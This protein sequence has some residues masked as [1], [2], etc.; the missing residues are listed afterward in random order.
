MI[1]G[2]TGENC[3]GKGVAAEY[4]MKKS[5]YYYSL[6]DVIREQLKEQGIPI[7]RENMI[8]K[9]NQLR[10]SLGPGALGKMVAQK[11]EEDKNY[12]IDSIR[13]PAEVEELKKLGR[14]FLFYI[15]APPKARFERIKAR[16]R[17]EDPKSYD[18][19]RRLEKLEAENEDKT[20]QN[21]KGTARLA[22][23][24][25]END[26][27][28]ELLQ[29]RIDNALAGLTNEF[30]IVRPGWD[31]YFMKIAK[32]VATR[33]N[34]VKRK[35]AAIIVKDKRIIST[36]YNGTPRGTKNCCDGGCPRCNN[37][38]EGGKNLEECYCSHGEENAIV[39][40]S[41]HG[42]SIKDS[43]IYTTFSPCLLCTKMIINAGIKEV[44]YNV[45]YPMGGSSLNLLKE[46]GV[47]VRQCKID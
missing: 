31:E 20:K 42:V 24:K 46:A 4:L 41:Y 28:L 43:T 14:F 12:V 22:D 30:K 5:F 2:L 13:N 23:K 9:G 8:K 3:A 7:T 35:V 10:E 32:V 38:T 44:V 1:I 21:L 26:S 15:T 45:D 36:G 17:E 47:K 40:A 27:T 18:A 6:S 11:L 16:K 19:F 37:F 34:C 33:S 29:E 25:I 39:Q